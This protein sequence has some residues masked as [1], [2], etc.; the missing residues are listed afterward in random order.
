MRATF[1][2]EH[3]SGKGT[4][5]GLCAANLDY[6]Y[7]VVRGDG[8][9]QG[10]LDGILDEDS[11]AFRLHLNKSLE[12]DGNG[13]G[14]FWDIAATACAQVVTMPEL[15]D[16]SL[17]IDRGPLSR[18][19][20]LLTKG[21]SGAALVGAMYPGYTYDL[22][23]HTITHDP[24]DVETIDFGNIIYL[25]VTA[26]TLLDRLDTSDPKFE[27]RKHNILQKE[28]LYEAAIHQLPEDTQS[29]II[30]INGDQAPEDVFTDYAEVLSS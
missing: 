11:L 8:T 28:G 27:F 25:Q 12:H 3:R 16:Q 4:Q 30:T 13:G 26:A 20:F 15:S 22:D 17:L 18:A 10:G 6:K 9:Y 21:L 2:G 5:I 7:L 19:A 24:V 1:D 23:G 29:R 14:N